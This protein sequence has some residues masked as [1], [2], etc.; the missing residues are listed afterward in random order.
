MENLVLIVLDSVGFGAMAKARADNIKGLGELHPA[1][2]HGSWTLPSMA[3]ISAG[4]LPWC[5]VE[6]CRH[7]R[8]IGSFIPKGLI[9][10]ANFYGYTTNPWVQAYRLFPYK[11][12]NTAGA[13]E[14]F[15]EKRKKPYRALIHVMETHWGSYHNLPGRNWFEK[16]LR[17]IE[18]VDRILRPVLELR[19]E[20]T[21]IVTGDHSEVEPRTGTGHD[22]REIYDYRLYEVFIVSSDV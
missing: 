4:V 6:G 18:N 12:L 21:I 7:R 22:P 8:V 14:D 13:V 5:V 3:S 10:G 15:L 16:Q 1:R 11:D 2:S 20:A 17:A 9:A 19:D